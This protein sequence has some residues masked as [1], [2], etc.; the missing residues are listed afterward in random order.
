[1]KSKML[2]L[3]LVITLF[4]TGCSGITQSTELY[5]PQGQSMGQ[6]EGINFT[7]NASLPETQDD[8]DYYKLVSSDVTIE[9]VKALG[10]KIGIPGEANWIPS[11]TIV[12]SELPKMLRVSATGHIQYI[13]EHSL[14]E[15]D[16]NLPS[17]EEATMIAT[18]F[19][20]ESG[21]WYDGVLLNNVTVGGT[22]NTVPSHLLVNYSQYI[23]GIPLTGNGSEFSVRIGDE[24]KIA[25]AAIWKPNLKLY[26]KVQC[27]KASDACNNLMAG[28]AINLSLPLNCKNV[29][30]NNIHL[31]YYLAPYTEGQEYVMP[32]YVFKGECLDSDGNFIEKFVAYVEANSK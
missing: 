15:L 31:G 16:A 26:G 7:L 13:V 1:M 24:G 21:L 2:L 12:M 19:L 5:Y 9:S 27:I 14:F 25:G 18:N 29:V 4:L 32:V 6:I 28:N 17:Y 23:N 20:K 8:I 30:I 22:I 10:N 11:D 3:T